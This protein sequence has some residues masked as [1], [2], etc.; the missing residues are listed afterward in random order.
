MKSF[1]HHSAARREWLRAEQT[2]RITSSEPAR[3]SNFEQSPYW[4]VCLAI[5]VVVIGIN[6]LSPDPDA[7]A[8]TSH[9]ARVTT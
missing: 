4:R 5:A 7:P 1:D 8:P 2:P 3:Q 6:V 9:A